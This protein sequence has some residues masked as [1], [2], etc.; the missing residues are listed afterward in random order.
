MNSRKQYVNPFLPGNQEFLKAMRD[1]NIW[2]HLMEDGQ[3]LDEGLGTLIVMVTTLNNYEPRKVL[4]DALNI[5]NA[6][7]SRGTWQSQDLKPLAEA[8][9]VVKEQYPLLP[10]Q[11]AHNSLLKALAEG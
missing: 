7:Q 9:R 8:L 11:V 3:E 10:K 1:Y 6:A 2:L 4:N 5:L